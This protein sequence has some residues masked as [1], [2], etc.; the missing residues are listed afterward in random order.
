[1]GD[2]DSEELFA[3]FPTEEETLKAI[4][5]KHNYIDR[6]L[7]QDVYFILKDDGFFSFKKTD[8][9]MKERAFRS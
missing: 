4:C 5:E 8:D 1:M 6:D 3:K 7:M 2:A 9:L